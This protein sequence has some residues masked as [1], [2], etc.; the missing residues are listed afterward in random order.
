LVL[1]QAALTV[2]KTRHVRMSH[3]SSRNGLERTGDEVERLYTELRE[4]VRACPTFD[5]LYASEKGTD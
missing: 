1:A 5:Q 4:E 2:T 3:P